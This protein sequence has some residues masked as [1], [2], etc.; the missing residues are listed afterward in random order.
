LALILELQGNAED[1]IARS[2]EAILP[3]LS[4]EDLRT[5]EAA[6]RWLADAADLTETYLAQ[7]KMD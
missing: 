6:S 3:Q 2:L 7:H 1:R 4:E 5:P